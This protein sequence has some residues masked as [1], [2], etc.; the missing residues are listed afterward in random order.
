MRC[1]RPRR[2][3]KARRQGTRTC[4]DSLTSSTAAQA[5]FYAAVA[6][7][8]ECDGARP[9]AYCCNRRS[10]FSLSAGYLD[11]RSN[12]RQE[13]AKC[14][15]F[16][17][18]RTYPLWSV[19]GF[20]ATIQERRNRSMHRGALTSI[21]RSLDSR[22]PHSLEGGANCCARAISASAKSCRANDRR[23]SRGDLPRARHTSTSQR[24][25]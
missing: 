5:P 6:V 16:I 21:P 7:G 9:F 17:G 19:A 12:H 4:R 10:R 13:P 23:S 8:Q 14:V 3:V 2:N 25:G 22:R 1:K 11:C 18:P 20:R 15:H 24:R